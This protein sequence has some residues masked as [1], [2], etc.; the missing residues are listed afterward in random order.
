MKSTARRASLHF[1][2]RDDHRRA[3]R[4]SIEDEFEE[5]L[6]SVLSALDRAATERELDYSQEFIEIMMREHKLSMDEAFDRYALLVLNLNEFF[7][8]D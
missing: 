8:I 6:P 7:F 5:P 2:S 4:Q 1:R 3:N